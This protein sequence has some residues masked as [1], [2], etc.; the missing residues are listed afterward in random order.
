[1]RTLAPTRVHLAFVATT[2]AFVTVHLLAHG[3]TRDLVVAGAGLLAV[4]AVGW[5]LTTREFAHPA[6]W[7]F[8][9]FG[10]VALLV[11]VMVFAVAEHMLGVSTSGPV[12]ILGPVLAFTTALILG[13]RMLF[14]S[15]AHAVSAALDAGVFAIAV[16]VVA[17]VLL[18]G[19][20]LES[21]AV[22]SAA[23]HAAMVALVALALVAGTLL[24]VART[25]ETPNGALGYLVLAATAMAVALIGRG[26]LALTD[27][28]GT[29]EGA[30]W[31]VAFCA[32]AAG[33]VHPS[34]AATQAYRPHSSRRVSAT[35][36]VGLGAALAAAPAIGLVRAAQG[37]QVPIA[38][39]SVGSLAV[40]PLVMLR[41]AALARTG[42]AAEHH[43]ARLAHHDELTGLANRRE[44]DATVDRALARLTRGENAG[45]VVVFCDLDGFKD[46]NDRH[47]H[48]VGDAVLVAA[49][50]RLRNALRDSD[51]V[52]RFGGDEF[53]VVAEGEPEP[54]EAGTTGRIRTAL[55]D[56][57][58][59]GGVEARLGASLG[60]A[61]ARPGDAITA[62]ELLSA[63]DTAMYRDKEET[64]R[65]R[66]RSVT[67]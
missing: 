41:I 31:I 35:L 16:S 59:V 5:S 60:A 19:P 23:Q 53:V 51:V 26:L 54:T 52:A 21:R 45:V 15:D 37:A 63:A 36:L 49:A 11:S 27:R 4:I 18:L 1:M 65:R 44:L 61:T 34:A 55:T 48:K 10:L 24:T 29:W 58:R 9:W 38:A 66:D 39:I 33:A 13:A 3:L 64:R 12:F 6:P 67:Q 47:G 17:W 56:P 30:V 25:L 2:A 40:I 32:A 43:L 50:R 42:A 28:P 20:L 62:T 57:I 46:V 14:H 22:P 7:R 8:L